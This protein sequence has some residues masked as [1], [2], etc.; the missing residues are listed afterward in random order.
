VLRYL[1]PRS[2]H[3][4]ETNPWRALTALKLNH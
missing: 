1:V 3:R 4:G 2:T